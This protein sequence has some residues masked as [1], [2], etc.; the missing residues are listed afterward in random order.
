MELKPKKASNP[1]ILFLKEN[2]AR[3]K[4]QHNCGAA[5]ETAK[6]LGEQWKAMSD[7]QKKPYLEMQAAEQKRFQDQSQEMKEKGYFTLPDG[8]KSSDHK[9]KVPV[10]RQ[11]LN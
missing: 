3:V 4:E 6:I 5:S 9:K 8:S 1:Y 11:K 10:K 2:Q 7:E